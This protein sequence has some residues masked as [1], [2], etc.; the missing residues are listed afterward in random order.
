MVMKQLKRTINCYNTTCVL[1]RP[2]Y[3]QGKIY[4]FEPPRKRKGITSSLEIV[5]CHSEEPETPIV[6]VEVWNYP[7]K[8]ADNVSVCELNDIYPLSVRLL[9]EISLHKNE[10]D[11]FIIRSILSIL[12]SQ[13]QDEIQQSSEKVK[14]YLQTNEIA[15]QYHSIMLFRKKHTCYL[16]LSVILFVSPEKTAQQNFSAFSDIIQ[17]LF[18]NYPEISIDV[19]TVLTNYCS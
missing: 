17:T 11:P 14:K 4:A 8:S 3:H 18:E 9:K 19:Y 12:T 13:K 7:T 5:K 16:L 6:G 2:H 10:V 15:Y 1:Y